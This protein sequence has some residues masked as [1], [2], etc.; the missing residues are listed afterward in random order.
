MKEGLATNSRLPFVL[1]NI[2]AVE[3]EKPQE[4]P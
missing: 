1:I 4:E 2:A 3:A